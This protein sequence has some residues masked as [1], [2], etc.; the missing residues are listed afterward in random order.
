MLYHV[1]IGEDEYLGTAEEV[2]RFMARAEGAP[3]HDI[4]SYMEGVAQRLGKQLEVDGIDPSDEVA[5]LLSLKEK[6]VLSIEELEE[7]S[8]ERV[9]PEKALGDGPVGLGPGVDPDDGDL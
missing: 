8:G 4:H 9:D 2:V 5:F 7:P 6:G 3:G 1:I